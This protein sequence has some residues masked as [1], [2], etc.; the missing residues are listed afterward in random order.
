MM[1]FLKQ[2]A[3]D[4]LK[5]HQP[6]DV[7]VVFP[8]RRASLFFNK[9]LSQVTNQPVWAPQCITI[10]DLFQACN[11][12]IYADNI[13]LV[14]ELFQIY[15]RHIPTNEPFHEFFYWGNMLVSDFDTI[16]KNLVN[17]NHLFRVVRNLKEIDSLFD[18]LTESQRAFLRNFWTNALH[19]SS[20]DKFMITWEKLYPI[21]SEYKASLRKSGMAYPGMVYRE[22]VEKEKFREL[23]SNKT[24][25]FVGFN[26]LQ[27]T[28]SRLIRVLADEYGA[29]IYWDLDHY[30]M[31]DERQEAGRFFRGYMKD[32]VFQKTFPEHF[33]EN[34][35]KEKQLDIYAASTI[36]DQVKMIGIKIGELL[37][38]DVKPEQIAIVLPDENL[39]F[40]VLNSLPENLSRLN[41]TM[42]F[43][44]R[45][46][47]VYS[48]SENI[49]LLQ[50]KY[51]RND[52]KVYRDIVRII[53]GTE[54]ILNCHDG[55]K[56]KEIRQLIQQDDLYFHLHQIADISPLCARI[57]RQIPDGSILD[58]LKDVI[59]IIYDWYEQQEHFLLEKEYLSHLTAHLGRLSQLLKE[60]SIQVDVPF[61]RQLFRQLANEM[62]IPFSGEP[63][64]GLQVM[65]VFET[66]NLDF[67]YVF[68]M[69]L[70]EGVFPSVENSSSYIPF[71]VRK[72]FNLPTTDQQDSIFAYL[73][74]RLL[75][76]SQHLHLFYKTG[77]DDIRDGEQSRF[78]LQ[79]EI[80]SGLP[81]RRHTISSDVKVN[82]NP[83]N[84]IEKS[85]YVLH[86]ID[87]FLQEGISPTA[88]NNYLDDPIT[89]FLQSVMRINTPENKNRII[90]ARHFGSL[91]HKS[92][93]Y[94]YQYFEGQTL[95]QNQLL[96][97]RGSVSGA[98]KLAFRDYFKKNERKSSSFEYEGHHLV[99][100]SVIE[101]FVNRIVDLDF[102]A[103]PLKII[104]NEARYN[105]DL[106]TTDGFAFRFKGNIDRVDQVGDV[107]R[108]IDYKTGG[109]K[110]DVRGELADLFIPIEKRN[111]AALQTLAYAFLY[112][113]NHPENQMKLLPGL[114]ISKELFKKDFDYRIMINKQPIVDAKPYIPLFE[115]ELIRLV[116]EIRNPTIPFRFNERAER[117]DMESIQF[118][119][120][121]K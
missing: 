17:A 92:I 23:Y 100:K 15:R 71:S 69:G 19:K 119:F 67:Q 115:K 111:K 22:V 56:K 104:S 13:T 114:F 37:S 14:F 51:M 8:N 59:Q 49:L 66:R 83:L 46:T 96:Q 52:Q 61:F 76:R 54:I 57:F 38:Q 7:V 2:V 65:G 86:Q 74:Y 102:N 99:V 75:Q 81:V 70:N 5:H 77:S 105:V 1:P 28:E 44:I 88:L 16:D 97:I 55:D 93:E 33:P 45:D 39:L 106:A 91:L 85:D 98:I 12:L 87:R 25:V 30:Y 78:L 47:P 60:N 31:E 95:Q 58:Y 103:L 62:R 48:L 53:L 73:F 117:P 11:D 108:L 43:P 32:R 72:A 9:Y 109:D 24:M 34:I 27:V 121:R 36:T 18:F 94:L 82:Q 118:A 29:R 26:A 64:E 3:A 107:I 79:L 113:R 112:Q 84:E 6:E 63:L 90:D 41:V 120:M 89:F 68:F 10:E 42:G 40:P 80:E 4:L 110:R 20:D 101:N 116:E 50:E 21:Y 35:V